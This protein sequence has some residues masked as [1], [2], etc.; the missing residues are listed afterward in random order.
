ML[1]METIRVSPI[2]CPQTYALPVSLRIYDV[3]VAISRANQLILSFLMSYNNY[4]VFVDSRFE[5][6]VDENLA[7]L[8][9]PASGQF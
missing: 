6:A 8:C 2:S 4:Y 3:E 1:D 5:C 7:Q 9:A